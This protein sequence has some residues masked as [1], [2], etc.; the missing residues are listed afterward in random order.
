[1]LTQLGVTGAQ[2]TASAVACPDGG[3]TRTVTAT[4]DRFTGALDARLH[5]PSPTVAGPRLYAYRT[6]DTGVA[7]RAHDD[8]LIVTATTPCQ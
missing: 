1:V 7:V 4:A 6:G 2:W 3:T 5:A 8:S